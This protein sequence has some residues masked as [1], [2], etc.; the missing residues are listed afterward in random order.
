ML[1][2]TLMG[3]KL[4]GVG[5]KYLWAYSIACTN[6]DLNNKKTAKKNWG[7]LFAVH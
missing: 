4:G 6:C 7:E 2:K 3:H 5:V 1:G